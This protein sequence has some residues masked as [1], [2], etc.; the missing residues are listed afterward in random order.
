M[1]KKRSICRSSAP[2]L[3]S[4][5]LFKVGVEGGAQQCIAERDRHSTL[6]ECKCRTRKRW[7]N[8]PPEPMQATRKA[9]SK[10]VAEQN[11]SSGNLGAPSDVYF[12]LKFNF[13]AA[14]VKRLP[15]G[16]QQRMRRGG[17]WSVL[18]LNRLIASEKPGQIDRELKDLVSAQPLKKCA[19]QCIEMCKGTY[20]RKEGSSMVSSSH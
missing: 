15:P 10:G 9:P 19:V 12:I 1:S 2:A 11:N 18:K 5:A 17:R 3:F 6:P 7:E 8:A 4:C 14:S 20:E 13:S 16:S